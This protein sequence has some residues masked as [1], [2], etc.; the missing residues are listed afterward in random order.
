MFSCLC[1]FVSSTKPKGT[2]R[3]RKLPS[4]PTGPTEASIERGF[5][6]GTRIPPFENDT[7]QASLPLPH[8]KRLYPTGYVLTFPAYSWIV[9]A[10]CFMHP[11]RTR[12]NNIPYAIWGEFV[13]KKSHN[14]FVYENDEV[15]INGSETLFIQVTYNT[16]ADGKICYYDREFMIDVGDYPLPAPPL[17]P[18]SKKL[19]VKGSLPQPKF[20]RLYPLGYV[21]TLPVYPWIIGVQYVMYPDRS[22]YCDI[23]H[24]SYGQFFLNES[25]NLLV[26]ENNFVRINGSERLIFD[27]TFNT[28]TRGGFYY[29]DKEV[30]I[31]VGDYPPPVVPEWAKWTVNTTEP[32]QT[33]EANSSE[34][35]GKWSC[36]TGKYQ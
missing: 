18:V 5:Y 19:T 21:M 10:Q 25:L 23:P 16:S 11:D 6:N 14:L 20:K 28:S 4:R 8:F 35:G 33:G 17:V 26:N 15:E 7:V 13:L 29:Y 27:M 36:V 32:Q 9:Q 3:V 31:N 30:T 34:T 24:A 2:W 12:Y 22:R 1:V